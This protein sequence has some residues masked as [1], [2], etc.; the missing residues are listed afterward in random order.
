[1]NKQHK[2]KGQGGNGSSTYAVTVFCEYCGLIAF[3]GNW[4]TS[5][6]ED[7]QKDAAQGCPCAPDTETEEE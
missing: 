2:F 1:M 6:N 5:S 4:S 3:H 7:H